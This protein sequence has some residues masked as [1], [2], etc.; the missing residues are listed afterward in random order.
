MT[1]LFR[2]NWD[3]PDSVAFVCLHCG[4]KTEQR[5]LYLWYSYTIDDPDDVF[6]NLFLR[7]CRVCEKFTIWDDDDQLIFPL[8]STTAPPPSPDMPDLVRKDYEEARK[9]VAISPRAAGALLRLGLQRLCEEILDKKGNIDGLIEQLREEERISTR[10]YKLMHTV[11]VIG[12]DAVHPGEMN[13]DEDAAIVSSLFDL[14]NFI[15]NDQITRP[16]EEDDLFKSLPANKRKAIEGR[17][18][19]RTGEDA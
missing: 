19:K 5:R 11:R 4:A 9:V 15:V 12:N 8:G 16:K 6:E 18:A 1:D 10:V 3:D 2:A 14:V 17:E 13:L 7:E